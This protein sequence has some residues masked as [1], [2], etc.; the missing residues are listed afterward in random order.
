MLDGTLF[1][2][3]MLGNNENCEFTQIGHGPDRPLHFS[4]G[5]TSEEDLSL[6][7]CLVLSSSL[8][9]MRVSL[10]ISYWGLVVLQFHSPNQHF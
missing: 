6:S 4:P 10:F 3:S 7:T 9:L 1:M 2:I 5:I 8:I